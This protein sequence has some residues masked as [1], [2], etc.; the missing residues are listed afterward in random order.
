MGMF[1][2][3]SYFFIRIKINIWNISIIINLKL[4]K[5]FFVRCDIGC[6]FFGFIYGGLSYRVGKL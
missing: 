1:F 5:K 4:E 3:Y 6:F 2:V